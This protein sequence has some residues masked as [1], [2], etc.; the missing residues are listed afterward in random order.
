MC[1]DGGGASQ[2]EGKASAKALRKERNSCSRESEEGSVAE[3]EG[4][5]GED[6]SQG[7]G[8]RET[9]PSGVCHSWGPQE[10]DSEMEVGVQKV[11]RGCS[12]NQH[13]WKGREWREE[14]RGSRMR[15][16]QE[17]S[18]NAVSVEV[19]ASPAGT[20]ATVHRYPGLG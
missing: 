2:A 12:W 20:W 11:I 15:W 5:R 19:S 18:S 9:T 6:G 14:R 7:R 8:Q 4:T 17:L 16:R 3:A 10:A 1:T 13:W